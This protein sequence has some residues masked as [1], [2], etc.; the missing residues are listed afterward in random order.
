MLFRSA[1][2]ILASQSMY[3]TR[4]WRDPRTGTHLPQGAYAT[5][6]AP[7][8]PMTQRELAE[9]FYFSPRRQSSA[10]L[11]W[12]VVIV[13]DIAPYFVPVGGSQ[14]VKPDGTVHAVLAWKNPMP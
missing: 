10:D 5:D 6:I 12:F 11:S 13:N 3:L 4:A 9:I 7:W 14:W 2:S 8:A 1:L